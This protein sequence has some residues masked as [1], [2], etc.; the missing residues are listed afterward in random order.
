M[1]VERGGST[2]V[3][4]NIGL[5]T[6]S[7]HLEHGANGSVL[8]LSGWH[9]PSEGRRT[10][11]ALVLRRRADAGACHMESLIL[12]SNDRDEE[13][14]DLKALSDF[15]FSLTN[16]EFTPWNVELGRMIWDADVKAWETHFQKFLRASTPWW[17][18]PLGPV[19]FYCVLHEHEGGEFIK[20]EAEQLK[21]EVKSTIAIRRNMST[22]L[23]P[24]ETLTPNARNILPPHLLLV[25]GNPGPRS[26]LRAVRAFEQREDIVQATDGKRKFE[27]HSREVL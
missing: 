20:S 22:L 1:S 24:Q 16:L 15:D 4:A 19:P 11:G 23:D 13:R 14:Q 9:L 2:A 3:C 10:E 6:H 17:K 7:P 26:H 27:G 5:A 25:H 12:S 8:E 21:F 18:F